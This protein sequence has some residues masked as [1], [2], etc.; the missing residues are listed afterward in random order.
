MRS[1]KQP[2]SSPLFEM[3]FWGVELN[4]D[5]VVP[6]VPPPEQARLHISQAC[7]ASEGEV[8]LKTSDWLT[9]R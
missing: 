8:A 5:K 1:I 2:V 3:S 6:Y 4:S 9:G 7:L